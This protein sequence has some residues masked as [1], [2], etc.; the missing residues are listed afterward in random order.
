VPYWTDGDAAA[1]VLEKVYHLAR[2]VERETGLEAYD[3]QVEATVAELCN[4]REKAGVEA[5]NQ[6]AKLFG[7][8][9]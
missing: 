9:S 5:F 8:R 7:R 6:V 1:A 3:P 2:T 4:G